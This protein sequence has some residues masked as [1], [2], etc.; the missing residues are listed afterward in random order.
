MQLKMLQIQEVTMNLLNTILLIAL[1]LSEAA[2]AY[3]SPFSVLS[4]EQCP[5]PHYSAS[6]ES[7]TCRSQPSSLPVLNARSGQPIRPHEMR[8]LKFSLQSAVDLG[9]V[10]DPDSDTVYFYTRWLVDS[11]GLKVGVLSIEGWVN[12]E[13]GRSARFDVRYNL[14]GDIVKITIKSLRSSN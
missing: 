13:M 2:L 9:L 3:Q 4:E 10:P 11:Q 6:E 1:S 8:Q 12:R 5:S 7:V 14:K